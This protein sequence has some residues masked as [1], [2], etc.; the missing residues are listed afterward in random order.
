MAVATKIQTSRQE[1]ALHN[2]CTTLHAKRAT[3]DSLISTAEFCG[4]MT[5]ISDANN[6]A[7]IAKHSYGVQYSS[8]QNLP[9][10][11]SCC[12]LFIYAVLSLGFFF[13][14]QYVQKGN[15]T[16]SPLVLHLHCEPEP[17]LPV[18]PVSSSV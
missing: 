17:S 12:V 6:E 14:N 11:P 1:N 9:L 10:V 2:V 8:V 7:P 16:F 4:R 18:I 5:G 15:C 13:F 3:P